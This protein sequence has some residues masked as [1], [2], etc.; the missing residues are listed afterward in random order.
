MRKVRRKNHTTNAMTMDL[1]H[2][3]IQAMNERVW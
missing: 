2:S 1:V 3:Q